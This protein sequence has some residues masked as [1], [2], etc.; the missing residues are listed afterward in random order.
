MT[1]RPGDEVSRSEVGDCNPN[2]LIDS[3]D[4]VCH[5]NNTLLNKWFHRSGLSQLITKH[6]LTTYA[7]PLKIIK[8]E[9][10]M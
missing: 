1:G 9:Y 10:N 4:P 5:N 6:L 7:E 3:T 8:N 2:C